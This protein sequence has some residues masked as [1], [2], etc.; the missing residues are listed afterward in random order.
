MGKNDII[1]YVMHS[2]YN[3][4][5]AVLKSML[6]SME[7]GDAPQY[8]GDYNTITITN[9]LEKTVELLGVFVVDGEVKTFVDL[10][11]GATTVGVIG[12]NFYTT[13]QIQDIVASQCSVISLS[14]INKQM[15]YDIGE[16]ASVTFHSG[17]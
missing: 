4:N 16:T 10:G 12:D 2:P 1:D 8:D 14:N 3:T 6:D 15:I 5:R 11:P 9:N 7:S 17:R 13:E